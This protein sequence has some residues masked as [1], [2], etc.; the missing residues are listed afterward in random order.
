M[1]IAVASGKGGTG[2]TTVAVNLAVLLGKNGQLVDCDVEAPNVHLFLKPQWT[3]K[4]TVFKTLPEINHDL[5]TFCGACQ[6][7]CQF[8]ALAVLT[9]E[10]LVFP[11]LC[12][13]CGGCQMV[14]PAKAIKEIKQEIGEVRQGKFEELEVVEGRLKIREPLAPPVIRAAKKLCQ[15]SKIVILD[16]PPGTACSMQT[17]IK[18]SDYCILVTEPSPFGLYDLQLATKVAQK[19]NIPAGVVIN[20][21]GLQTEEIEEWCNLNSLPVLARIPFSQEIAQICAEGSLLVRTS[22]RWEEE[23]Q[24]LGASILS[25]VF[26]RKE[27]S[28]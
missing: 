18:G 8:Q 1:L 5:C 23:F 16:S 27:R 11:E 28:N 24:Q 26:H 3:T 20:K 6:N 15:P 9:E 21:A 17:T 13:S 4:N 22:R 19:L 7:F 10:V 2:K 14:C 12:H 25:Q